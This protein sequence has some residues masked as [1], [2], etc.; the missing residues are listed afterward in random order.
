ME[1][2]IDVGDEFQMKA[3]ETCKYLCEVSRLPKQRISS[4]HLSIFFEC[5]M[6]LGRKNDLRYE[7]TSL[8]TLKVR[9]A[10]IYMCR[11]ETAS[12]RIGV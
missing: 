2:L 6:V 1:F 3:A 8:S 5:L 4:G 11:K 9:P 12:D 10:V 7:G